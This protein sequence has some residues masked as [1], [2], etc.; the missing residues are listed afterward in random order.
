MSYE[1]NINIICKI[2]KMI[3]LVI[4]DW[5]GVISDDRKPV[6]EANMQL[7]ID[8]A[9]TRMPMEQWIALTGATAH[10]FLVNCGI[11]D[12]DPNE[13]F[14]TY[15]RYFEEFSKQPRFEPVMY[16]DARQAL[17]YLKETCSKKLAILSTHPEQDLLKE[18]EGYGL[19]RFFERENI[20]ASSTN[21]VKG[22][23][24]IC[25]KL[26]VSG[27]DTLFL[28]DMTYDIDAAREAGIYSAAVCGGYHDEARLKDCNP[29][30]L[31]KNGIGDI[32]FQLA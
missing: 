11:T 9:G 21:K 6:Y 12:A 17:Q 15:Q 3:K 23:E 28:G 10:G 2:K 24:D 29:D 25:R 31:L 4:C 16:P 13:T 30:W 27:N 32:M 14:E 22:I 20:F 7:L 8:H 19:S 1:E 5:S 18:M 26:R